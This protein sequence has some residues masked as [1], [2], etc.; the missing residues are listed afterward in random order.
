MI[1]VSCKVVYDFDWLKLS[2]TTNP[3]SLVY[4]IFLLQWTGSPKPRD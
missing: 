3:N 2:G 4:M 1:S